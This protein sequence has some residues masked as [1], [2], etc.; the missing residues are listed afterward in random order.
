MIT[1]API[2]DKTPMTPKVIVSAGSKVTVQECPPN[3]R[4]VLEPGA[5][6]EVLKGGELT[7]TALSTDG[8]YTV[9][10]TNPIKGTSFRNHNDATTGDGKLEVLP[11][12]ATEF[13]PYEAV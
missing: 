8:T 4:V 11:M 12:G 10:T 13:V 2:R 1:K 3:F 9:I 6:I 7:I 5:A